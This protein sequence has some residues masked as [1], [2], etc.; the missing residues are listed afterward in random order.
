[1]QVLPAMGAVEHRT[2]TISDEEFQIAIE[3]KLRN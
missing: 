1:M 2:P 3:V